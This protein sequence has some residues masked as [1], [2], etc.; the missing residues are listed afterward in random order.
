MNLNLPR[1]ENWKIFQDVLFYIAKNNLHY[2]EN[3]H[4]KLH[5]VM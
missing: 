3:A 2:C 5:M 1:Y 4:L